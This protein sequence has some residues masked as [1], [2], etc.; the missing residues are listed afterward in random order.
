MITTETLARFKRY[1]RMLRFSKFTA[2]FAITH[3]FRF[4]K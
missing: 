4:A 3:R 2:A 1:K